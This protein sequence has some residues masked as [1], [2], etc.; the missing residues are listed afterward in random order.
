MYSKYIC[1][2]A[3]SR[4]YVHVPQTFKIELLYENNKEGTNRANREFW[5]HQRHTVTC[6]NLSSACKRADLRPRLRIQCTRLSTWL[7]I[8]TLDT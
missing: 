8:G 1:I 5:Y 2:C 3:G 4:I 7:D 6:E